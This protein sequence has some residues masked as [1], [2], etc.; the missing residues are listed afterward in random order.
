[1]T[2]LLTGSAL[3]AQE[4]QGRVSYERV[5]QI[6]FRFND[7]QGESIAQQVPRSRTDKFE[8][9]YADGKTLWKAAEAENDNDQ[10][11]SSDGGMQIRMVVSGNDDVLYTDLAA[12]TRI[13]KREMFDKKFKPDTPEGEKLQ[14]ALLLIKQYEDAHYPIPVPDP[15]DAVK[16]KMQL[17]GLK[18]K[19]LVGKV[20]TKGYVSALLNKHKPLTLGIGQNFSP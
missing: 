7:T 16:L 14:M 13:E 2:G 12:G 3:I 11:T 1:M 17:K 20:G 10:F 5:S 9:H 8:L 19:D 6:Q 15:I 4:N 18:N